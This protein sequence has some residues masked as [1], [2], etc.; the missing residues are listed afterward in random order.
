[1]TA[2]TITTPVLLLQLSGISPVQWGPFNMN[3]AMIAADL[4]MIM[5]GATG[6]LTNND[7]FKWTLYAIG[8]VA[9]LIIF[10]IVWQILGTSID[11]FYKASQNGRQS[12]GKSEEVFA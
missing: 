11:K 4:I 3:S 5:C 1:M 2:W 7:A 10:A 12:D 9:M 8:C 6:L